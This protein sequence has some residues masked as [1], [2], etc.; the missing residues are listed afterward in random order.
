MRQREIKRLRRGQFR[1][2]ILRSRGPVA[3]AAINARVSMRSLAP[4][5]GVTYSAVKM[6]DYR[7]AAPEA[8]RAALAA[9]PFCVPPSA[10]S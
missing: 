6:W 1:G 2:P 3:M 8:V 4:I 7:K 10:W 9:A 5:F